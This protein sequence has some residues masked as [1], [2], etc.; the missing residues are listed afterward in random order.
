MSH[1]FRL[2]ALQCHDYRMANEP[3]YTSIE[4]YE[5]IDSSAALLN[6]DR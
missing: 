2:A 1:I 5:I 6:L 4:R 3:K